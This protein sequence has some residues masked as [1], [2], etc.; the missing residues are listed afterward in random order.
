MAR[1]ADDIDARA[2]K[3][4]VA[5]RLGRLQEAVDDFTKVLDAD[6]GR[7]PSPLPARADLAPPGPVAGSPGGPRPR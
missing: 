5:L 7:D 3:G 4:Q 1:S 2:M 6:P